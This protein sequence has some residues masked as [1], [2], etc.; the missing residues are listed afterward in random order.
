MV[1]VK[2][3]YRKSGGRDIVSSFKNIDLQPGD[4]IVYKN[5]G[6]PSWVIRNF[7]THDEKTHLGLYMGNGKVGEAI[8]YTGLPL[9]KWGTVEVNDFSD[10]LKMA[11]GF[12]VYRP[13]V[14]DKIKENAINFVRERQ[15]KINRY[16]S[17]NYAKH[18][19]NKILGTKFKIKPRKNNKK[20]SCAT[21][22]TRAYG[23][24]DYSIADIPETRLAM[25]TDIKENDN[26]DYRY[27]IDFPNA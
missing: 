13:K 6:F 1:K 27:K 10:S 3:E 16:D 18:K 19:V 8:H 11:K 7:E 17:W 20:L 12:E 4:I 15:G 23:H 5:K 9:N 26:L 21:L 24:Q 14:S 22:A 25:A 2:G